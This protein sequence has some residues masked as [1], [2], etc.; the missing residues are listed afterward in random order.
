MKFDTS[1]FK[2]YDI[3]GS[4]PETINEELVAKIGTAF[5]N[6]FKLKSVAIGRDARISSPFLADALKAGITKAGA[7]VIDLGIVSS[8]MTYFASAFYDDIDGAIMVTASH[9]PSQYN[10]LKFCLSDAVAVS[11]ETGLNDIRDMI[12]EDKIKHTEKRGAE[13]SRDIYREYGEKLLAIA[14][15]SKKTNLKVAIDAGNGV[16]GEVITKIFREAPFEI[17]PLYFEADGRFPNHQ[18]NPIEEKNNLD[19]MTKVIEEKADLGIAFDGDGDRA[20]FIDENGKSINSTIITALIAEYLLTKNPGATIVHNLLCG[21]IVAETIKK[22]GGK[23]IETKVGHSIIKPIMRENQAVFGGEHSG[24]YFFRDLYFADS[25]LLA[26]LYVIK[27][28]SE[29]N[30]PFSQVVTKYEKYFQS[31]ELNFE[32]ENA[33]E[34]VEKIK[35]KYKSGEISELDGLS[36]DFHNWHFN[37]RS[38]NTEPLLRLNVEAKTKETMEEKR[39]EIS[40]IIN[41]L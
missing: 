6:K 19:L 26:S 4:Y 35:D 22:C 7:D 8:D 18:A 36:V 12:L 1:I 31:G 24:H 40:K 14:E 33:K 28:L 21:R 10:G 11:A 2:S 32:V 29:M 20:F 17:S 30:L 13:L 37:V 38:S 9:N 3:R 25:G 39:D 27:I 15:L 34:V 5:V 16:A 41:S 23:A